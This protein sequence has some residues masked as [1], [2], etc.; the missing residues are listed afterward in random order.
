MVK[1][2]NLLRAEFYKLSKSKAF[3]VCLLLAICISI[4]SVIIVPKNEAF[5]TTANA[6]V[7][8]IRSAM[9]GWMLPKDA[10][11]L[12]GLWFM[13]RCLGTGDILPIILAIMISIFITKEFQSRAINNIVS[14]GFSK[15]KVYFSKLISVSISAIFILM[16]YMTVAASLASVWLGFGKFNIYI[17]SEITRMLLL[18]ILLHVSIASIFTMIAMIVRK[19]GPAIAINICV[20]ILISLFYQ[21]IMIFLNNN[22]N[23]GQYW[24]SYNVLVLESLEPE[25]RA[26]IRGIMVALVFFTLSTMIG[27]IN[28]NK[29]DI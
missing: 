25:G 3:Y 9:I 6:N 22:I 4:I 29:R 16:V 14:K 1:I 19:S 28:F 11:K 23:I 20:V 10:K 15:N 17:F 18:Q 12:K 5:I 24:I 26:V 21:L 13:S 8:Q 7:P 2:I 27:C